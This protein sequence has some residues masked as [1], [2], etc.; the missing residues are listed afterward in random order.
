MLVDSRTSVLKKLKA[1][2]QS[3]VGPSNPPK[4]GSMNIE[5]MQ[6]LWVTFCK[7]AQFKELAGSYTQPI[8][9]NFQ[10]MM[11]WLNFLANYHIDTPISNVDTIKNDM[12]LSLKLKTL[13]VLHNLNFYK[14]LPKFM[15]SNVYYRLN[16]SMFSDLFKH[17]PIEEYYHKKL[18][19]LDNFF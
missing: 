19:P 14:V 10:A 12:S 8:D 4:Y 11:L 16:F 5:E 9:Y 2:V 1:S 7:S 6:I 15:I 3:R 17:I 18:C 13:D